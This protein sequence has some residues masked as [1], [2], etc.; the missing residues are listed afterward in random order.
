MRRWNLPWRARWTVAIVGR[1]SG[2]RTA[3]DGIY[4]FRRMRDALEKAIELNAKTPDSETVGFEV[5][6]RL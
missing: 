3:L 1:Y 4:R 6:E 2:H 5:Q